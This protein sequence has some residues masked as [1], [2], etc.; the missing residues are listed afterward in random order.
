MCTNSIYACGIDPT[1]RT[2]KTARLFLSSIPPL[3]RQ[4]RTII[5]SKVLV[6]GS[7]DSPILKVVF[8]D[9]SEMEVNPSDLSFQEVANH[10]DR[11]SRQLSLKEI[12]EKQ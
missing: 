10:F 5:Q 8:K 3:Q 2:A 7:T 6:N 11:Y 4:Q 1:F 9:K 12:I